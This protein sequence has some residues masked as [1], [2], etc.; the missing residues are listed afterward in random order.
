MRQRAQRASG[1]KKGPAEAALSQSSASNRGAIQQEIGL[2][3][4]DDS[5]H[6]TPLSPVGGRKLPL[7]ASIGA[8]SNKS[9][10]VG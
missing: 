7:G 2:L 5:L 9:G 3:R 6:H 10:S 1:L 4:I 8:T